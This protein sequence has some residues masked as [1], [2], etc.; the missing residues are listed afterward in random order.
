MF[1][2]RPTYAP[3]DPEDVQRLGLSF[4]SRRCAEESERFFRRQPHDPC[5]CSEVFR[6]AIVDRDPHAWTCVYRQY[7]PLVASWVHRHTD[8]RATGEDLDYFVNL[9]FTR[10]WQSLT[11]E[12]YALSPDLK[13]L[14]RY[15]SMCVHSAI[16]DHVRATETA[17]AVTSLAELAPRSDDLEVETADPTMNLEADTLAGLQRAEVWREIRARLHDDKEELVL[18]YAYVM[19]LKPREIYTHLAGTFE[20]VDE[21]YGIKEKVLCRLRRDN[22][23]KHLI[24]KTLAGASS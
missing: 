4:V 15:L 16:V 3:S 17:D 1:N 14:L 24:G 13:S 5:F 7:R 10:F 19:G 9:A 11:P 23:L 2:L 21:V 18:Y 8:V 12:R 6:R 20:T 22:E